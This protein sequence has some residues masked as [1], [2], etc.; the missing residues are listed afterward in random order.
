[1]RERE[2]EKRRE[3]RTYHRL[4]RD[5][6]L[7]H[8]CDDLSSLSHVVVS[9]SAEVEALSTTKKEKPSQL[10]L[11]SNSEEKVKH[12]THERPS[13]VK[14]GLSDDLVVL[15]DHSERSGSR[16]EEEIERATLLTNEGKTR[17]AFVSSLLFGKPTMRRRGVCIRRT[18]QEFCTL[19][20]QVGARC[21]SL[22]S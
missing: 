19:S 13:R 12:R 18:H 8:L 20:H 3:R 6:R 10:L 7:S 2:D 5:I 1:M 4:Q 17:R 11:S 22:E 14:R 16:S 21:P 9:P 15:F